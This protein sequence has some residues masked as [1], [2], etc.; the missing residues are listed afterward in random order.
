MSTINEAL[1]KAQKQRDSRH[2]GYSRSLSARGRGMGSL[3]G[4][5]VL[6]GSLILM[7]I[8]LAF[9]SDSWLDFWIRKTPETPAPQNKKPPTVRVRAP[10]S[11][12]DA[13][14][15]YEKARFFHRNGSLGDAGRLYR[16][17][18]RVDP[19]YV[20]ALNNLGVIY[21]REKE[22]PAAQISFEKAIRLKPDYVEPYYNLAC[23]HAIK[24]EVRESLDHLKKA[25]LLDRSVRD[26]ARRDTDLENL[27][28]LP[29][30]AE[31][32][33]HGRMEGRGKKEM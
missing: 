16:E 13:K 27:R 20:D 25:V 10:K 9:E 17:T 1:K 31:I 2:K 8:F 22:Y 19:G 28:G 18:L 26:W 21:I 33:G 29:E 23:L 24:G 3:F 4:R 30:F 11:T 6:W 5:S 14:E 32:I 7:A 12:A 15:S